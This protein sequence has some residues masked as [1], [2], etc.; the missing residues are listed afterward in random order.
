MGC[1]TVTSPKKFSST[2]S[3]FGLMY[4]LHY[5]LTSM[6]KTYTTGGMAI[7]SL[8]YE[9]TIQN[10]RV[11]RFTN[12]D[13]S[14]EVLVHSYFTTLGHFLDSTFLILYNDCGMELSLG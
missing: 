6:H 3:F 2:V 12:S 8:L 10:V 14:S 4:L 11:S 9:D 5:C 7:H 1:E 13:I